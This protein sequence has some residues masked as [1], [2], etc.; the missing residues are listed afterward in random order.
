[1]C[2]QQSGW[3]IDKDNSYQNHQDNHESTHELLDVFTH[4]FAMQFWQAAT[5]M[6]YGHHAGKVI[7]NSTGKDGTQNYP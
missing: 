1:M 5:V 7:V 4:V 6:A 2:V 3:S